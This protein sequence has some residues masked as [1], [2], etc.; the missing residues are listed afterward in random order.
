[1]SRAAIRRSARATRWLFSRPS[2][3]AEMSVVRVQTEDFDVAREIA[4][5]RGA[6][7]RG[8]ALGRSARERRRSRGALVVAGRRMSAALIAIDWGTTTARAYRFDASGRIVRTTSAPLGVQ[9]VAAG[10]FSA[11]LAA[12]LDG[13]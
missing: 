4:A 13:V 7:A 10:G 12:L 9:K 2:P 1:M 3:G 6:D 8:R 11:A 5:L